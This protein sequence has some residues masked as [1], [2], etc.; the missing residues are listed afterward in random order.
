MLDVLAS[1]T[2]VM[3]P[4][5]TLAIGLKHMKHDCSSNCAPN[6]QGGKRSC[7]MTKKANISSEYI[8]LPIQSESDNGVHPNTSPSSDH[9]E[10]ELIIL[11]SNP[12]KGDA[13]PNQ[14]V[15]AET[16][17]STGD[18]DRDSTGDISEDETDHGIEESDSDGESQAS[19]ANSDPESATGYCLT[20]SDMEEE[21][22]RSSHKK[23][24]K[25][26]WASCSPTNQGLWRN[27]QWE[28]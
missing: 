27:A 19:V 6:D 3:L 15:V 4:S 9:P 24:N 1:S 16:L 11:P 21:A 25:K 12:V 5:L 10:P 22:V 28:Q 23:F 26:V 20:C 13:D 14:G 7:T 18:H 8:F 2:P 17:G